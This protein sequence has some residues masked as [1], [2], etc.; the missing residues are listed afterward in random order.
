MEGLKYLHLRRIAHL[1]IKPD[2][3]LL[4]ENNTIKISDFS[5]SVLV[6]EH[7]IDEDLENILNSNCMVGRKEFIFPE[8]VK[9]AN[10][11]EGLENI[12]NSNCMVGRKEFIF[13]KM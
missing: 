4:G 1:D 10:I 12:L 2:N 6:K 7:N 13:L 9:Q 5:L 8:N 3:I 11:N